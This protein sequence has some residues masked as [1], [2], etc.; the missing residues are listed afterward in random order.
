MNSAMGV[1]VVGLNHKVA[2]IEVREGAFVDDDQAIRA[3]NDL[4]QHNGVHAAAILSTCNR[5]EIYVNSESPYSG[6]SA[7]LSTLERLHPEHFQS[8][9]HFLYTKEGKEAIYHIFRVA[10]GL[11]SMLIGEAQV[12][13]QVKNS[14]GLAEAAGTLDAILGGIIRHAVF[15]GK[16]VRSETALGR[17]AVSLSHAA[18]EQA[19]QVFGDLE[20]RNVVVVGAGEMA[21]IAVD[22]LKSQGIGAVYVTSRSMTRARGLA[23]LYGGKA[24][25]FKEIV[26]VMASCDLLISSSSAPYYLITEPTVRDIMHKRKHKPL[27][28]IDMA[29]PRDV[30]PSAGKLDDVYLYNL[31]DLD[32]VVKQNLAARQKEIP[33][34]E[35]IIDEEVGKCIQWIKAREAA[36]VIKSIVSRAEAIRQREV[37]RTLKRLTD[38]NDNVKQAINAMTSSLVNKML[39]EVILYLK[40]NPDDGDAVMLLYRLLGDKEKDS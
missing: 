8:Y 1:V 20:G 14:L 40:E 12:L 34:A 3:L 24:F 39:H 5:T 26:E 37:E 33:K 25:E 15:A 13:A 18:V 27:L 19:K 21:R 32:A 6:S 17:G 31:D 11:D 28:I 22:L 30:E 36:P 38:V 16:R 4:R 35:A 23:R 29:V 7:A 2:P 10:A 9:Q